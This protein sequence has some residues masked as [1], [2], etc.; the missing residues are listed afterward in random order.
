MLR[1]YY[2]LPFELLYPNYYTIMV[3]CCGCC[4]KNKV[5]QK[6]EAMGTNGQITLLGKTDTNQF[7]PFLF[8]S[9]SGGGVRLNFTGDGVLRARGGGS[10]AAAGELR[11]GWVEE[12][13]GNIGR[14]RAGVVKNEGGL[15]LVG[16]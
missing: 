14:R 13:G 10:S 4:F 8:T 15:L 1:Q 11:G 7:L 6:K 16:G 5:F 3:S 12:G 9:A 2:Y